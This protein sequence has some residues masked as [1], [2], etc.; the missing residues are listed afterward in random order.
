MKYLPLDVKH[1][2][3]NQSILGFSWKGS[4][5][6]FT[7]LP[8]GLLSA[9]FIFTKCLKAMVKFW[10]QNAIDIV[11]YLDDGLGMSSSVDNCVKDSFFVKQSLLDA[12]F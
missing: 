10:R 7:V 11:L 2:S 8:F 3:I 6:C 9:P 5:Y 12:S 1:H 4:F